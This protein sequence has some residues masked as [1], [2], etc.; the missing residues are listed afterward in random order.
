[1]RGLKFRILATLLVAPLFVNAVFAEEPNSAPVPDLYSDVPANHMYAPAIAYMTENNF[2][3][4]YA[5]GSFLPLQ[6]INR[7]EALKMILSAAGISVETST[8]NATATETVA[9]SLPFPDLEE[10][11]WY[12]PYVETAL[13]MEI[14]N[15]N[16]DGTFKPESTVNRAEALKMLVL[17]MDLQTSLPN[18]P[19]DYWYS[20]YMAYGTENALILPN[21]DGNFVPGEPLT[22]GELSDIIFRQTSTSFTGETEYGVASFYGKSFDGANTASGTALDTDGFMAAHK[23]LPFGTVVRITNLDANLFV[24]VTIVDR[25]PYVEGRIIDLTPAAFEAIGSLGSG[26]LNVR[27]E[28]LALEVLVEIPAE[29]T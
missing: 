27:L 1:M 19:D 7:A 22:R 3:E 11:A 16:G 8:T 4:G 29:E 10:N 13:T 26:V 9:L 18:I 23:T 6:E 2:A 5:D 15:G 24:D 28:V 14:V 20:A 25:G 12:L 17:A 21:F